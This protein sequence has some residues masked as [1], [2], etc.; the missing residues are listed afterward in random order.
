MIVTTKNG[1]QII[2]KHLWT[3][4]DKQ[5]K[6]FAAQE[7][8]CIT[9]INNKEIH[10]IDVLPLLSLADNTSFIDNYGIISGPH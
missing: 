9:D 10:S 8:I 1:L 4:V 5:M 2:M 3:N 7:R 6:V